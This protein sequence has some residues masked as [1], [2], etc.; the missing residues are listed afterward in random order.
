MPPRH[1]LYVFGSTKDGLNAKM[2]FF[3]PVG[4]NC[5]L[6]DLTL[7]KQGNNDIGGGFNDDPL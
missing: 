4:E 5:K 6:H 1:G 7:T 2:T 3:V